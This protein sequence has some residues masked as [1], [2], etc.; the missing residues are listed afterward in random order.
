M[1]KGT[2][3]NGLKVEECLAYK[4][5]EEGISGTLQLQGFFWGDATPQH[6]PGPA[7]GLKQP[8]TSECSKYRRID[9]ICGEGRPGEYHTNII[10]LPHSTD[11]LAI[12]ENR[13]TLLTAQISLL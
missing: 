2:H 8:Q 11:Y 12:A 5:A 3:T 9:R 10:S 13:R 4:G 6:T 1:T 7:R